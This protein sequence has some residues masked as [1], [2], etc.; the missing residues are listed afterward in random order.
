[1]PASPSWPYFG[2]DGDLHPRGLALRRHWKTSSSPLQTTPLL[3]LNSLRVRHTAGRLGRLSYISP[4]WSSTP[5]HERLGGRQGSARDGGGAR[6]GPGVPHAS[7]GQPEASGGSCGSGSGR[8]SGRPP[9]NAAP[10]AAARR[11]PRSRPR[12]SPISDGSAHP[13]PALRVVDPLLQVRQL[14][15]GPVVITT[16]LS[17]RAA[18][19]SNARFSRSRS[20]W[21]KHSSITMSW[22]DTGGFIANR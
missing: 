2:A 11:G 16:R 10:G 19:F 15:L 13:Q 9:A 21:S 3:L 4:Q 8:A 17:A 6:A 18:T 5:T 1:M 20:S 12:W 14:T 22:S 7:T